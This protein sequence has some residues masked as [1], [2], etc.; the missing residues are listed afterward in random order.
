MRNL[1]KA[2]LSLFARRKYYGGGMGAIIDAEQADAVAR[3]PPDHPL[4]QKW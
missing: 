4:V 2:L 3:M 1:L